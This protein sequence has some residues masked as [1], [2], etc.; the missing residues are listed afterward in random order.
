MELM[1]FVNLVRIHANMGVIT[2]SLKPNLKER[3]KERKKCL[4]YK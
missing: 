3:K 4:L 2:L 1:E